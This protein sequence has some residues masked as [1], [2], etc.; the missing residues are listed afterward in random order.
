MLS[1]VALAG[2]ACI[3]HALALPVLRSHSYHTTCTACVPTVEDAVDVRPTQYEPHDAA[4]T[5]RSLSAGVPTQRVHP[6]V[7]QAT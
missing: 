4:C 1:V 6:T 7:Q 5:P 2:A 3:T